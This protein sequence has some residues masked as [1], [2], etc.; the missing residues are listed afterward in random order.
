MPNTDLCN[1]IRRHD[2]IR[3][4]YLGA[5]RK[6]EPHLLG[7]DASGDLTLSAWQLEGPTPVGWRDFHVAKMQ[8]IIETGDTFDRGRPGY[9]RDDTTVV[10]IICRLTAADNQRPEDAGPP[11]DAGNPNK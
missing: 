6:V 11:D 3:F 1:Y 2:I 5:M 7:L 4:I 8:D 10:N 9:N